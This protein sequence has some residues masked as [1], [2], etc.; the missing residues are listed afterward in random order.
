MQYAHDVSEVPKRTCVKGVYEH[1]KGCQTCILMITYVYIYI[2]Y[3]YYIY[4][5]IVIIILLLIIII[6]YYY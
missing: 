1:I 5:Y 2:C 3:M 6:N 4:I